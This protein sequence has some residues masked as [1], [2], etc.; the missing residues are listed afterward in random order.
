MLSETYRRLLQ[1]VMSVAVIGLGALGCYVLIVTKPTP[2][3]IQSFERVLEVATESVA[4]HTE[5]SPIVGY[6]TV[7][8]RKQIEV[9]PLVSGRLVHAHS[10]LAPG[11]IIPAG[12][13]LFELDPTIYQSRVSQVKAEIA[14]LEASVGR[15]DQELTNLQDRL[16]GAKEMLELDRNAYETTLRLYE[17]D[18]VGTQR[19]VDLE[20]KQMLAQQDVVSGLANSVATIPHQKLEIQAK[21]EGARA[22]L[23][24][25]E[26]N[27]DATKIVAPFDARVE[28]VHAR[29]SQVVMAHLS[30]ATLTDISAFELSVGIDPREL[31]W[32]DPTLHP[33]ALNSDPEAADAPVTVRW[34]LHGQEYTW[35]GRVS[36]FERVD[37]RTRTLQ[38][39]VEVLNADMQASVSIGGIDMAP[40][41]SIGM[42]CSAELPARELPGAVMVPRHAVHENRWV[43]VFEAEDEH[44]GRLARREISVLRSMG[45]QVLVD[46]DDRLTSEP[47]ELAVGDEM[48]VSRLA[49][50]VLGMRV[51]RRGS[52]IACQ[53]QNTPIMLASHDVSNAQ[54]NTGLSSPSSYRPARLV[55]AGMT[56]GDQ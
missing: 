14:G 2:K 12:T 16:E 26:Y 48:V 53:Q 39:V 20:R 45:D 4:V 47:C 18:K 8:P 38:M 23:K 5:Q 6:G 30:I 31:R 1:F 32:L 51:R 27:L 37:E 3:R 54:S 42:F 10:D 50:P 22:S 52:A 46:F 17:D 24:Q 28:A 15:L 44:F 55:S 29:E 40:R 21:L 25:A 13:L 9:V 43:Y 41:L 7:R 56:P 49:K 11:K 19:G 34:S 36:R 35:N 33:D